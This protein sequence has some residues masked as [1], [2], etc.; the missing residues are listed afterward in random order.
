[1]KRIYVAGPYTK[2]DVAMNVRAACEAGTRLIQAGHA[3]FIPHLFHFLHF[4]QPQAYAM[5]TAQDFEWLQACDALLRLPGESPGADAEV[6]L[7]L[8]A[9][10]PVYTEMD[11][12]LSEMDVLSKEMK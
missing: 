7:A 6:R 12:L 10:I 9:N 8:D 11:V 4:Y 1:M 5:W 3:P 2:G